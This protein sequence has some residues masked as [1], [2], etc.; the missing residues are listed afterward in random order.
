MNVKFFNLIIF[1]LKK[2]FFLFFADLNVISAK[3]FLKISVYLRDIARK[4]MVHL[5]SLIVFVENN[6]VPEL[7]LLNIEGNILALHYI[8]KN[9]LIL[10]L[11]FNSFL[12]ERY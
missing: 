12:S 11:L 10:N 7:L 6:F 3:K 9:E 8:S 2:I 4:N 5:H 1:I